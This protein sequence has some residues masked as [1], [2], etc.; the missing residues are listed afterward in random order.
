MSYT[1][2]S[3]PSNFNPNTPLNNN[4]NTNNN[5][6]NGNNNGNG[7]IPASISMTELRGLRNFMRDHRGRGEYHNNH[8]NNNNN[9]VNQEGRSI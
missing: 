7:N 9:G 3:Q 4:T 1:P 2:V 8:N 6:N 5:N